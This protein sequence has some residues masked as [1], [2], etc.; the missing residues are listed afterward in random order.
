MSTEALLLLS[1]PFACYAELQCSTVDLRTSAFNQWET[2]AWKPAGRIQDKKALNR[3][4]NGEKPQRVLRE[5]FQPQ[6]AQR[7]AMTPEGK[8][9]ARSCG[10]RVGPPVELAEQPHEAGGCEIGDQERCGALPCQARDG[11]SGEI[12]AAHGTFHRRRPSRRSPVAGEIDSRPY[13]LRLRTIQ[14]DSG[15]RRVRCVN[16]FDD[17]RLQKLGVAC[18][19]KKL[20]QLLHCEVDDFLP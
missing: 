7:K 17:R 5:S 20:F 10:S 13:R 16:F 15:L 9:S 2:G 12:S 6:R 11:L 19:G 4:E 1:Q 18:G 8:G 14:F 3:R